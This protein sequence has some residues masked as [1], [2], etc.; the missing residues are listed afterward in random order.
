MMPLNCLEAFMLGYLREL[1]QD[2]NNALQV[3]TRQPLSL[4]ILDAT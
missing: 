2:N 1:A 4:P 3:W